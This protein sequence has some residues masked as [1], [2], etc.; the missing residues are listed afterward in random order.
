MADLVN[1]GAHFKCIKAIICK[2]K[3]LNKCRG[4]EKVPI[5]GKKQRNTLSPHL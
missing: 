5:S 1:S 4:V 2:P 3:T